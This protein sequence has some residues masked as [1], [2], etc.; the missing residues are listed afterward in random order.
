MFLTIYLWFM[1]VG[2]GLGTLINAYMINK[3]VPKPITHGSF[4]RFMTSLV[5]TSLFVFWALN[6]MGKI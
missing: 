4:G 5:T 2:A 3:P 1:M 6:V